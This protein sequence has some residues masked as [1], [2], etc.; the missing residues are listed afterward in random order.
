MSLTWVLLG[1]AM[2]SALPC[3]F[4]GSHGM[5][6]FIYWLSFGLPKGLQ[7]WGGGL[8][9]IPKGCGWRWISLRSARHVGGE[10]QFPQGM[11]NKL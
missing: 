6:G 3:H 1:L 10:R 9:K 8:R 2:V 5:T 7:T 4:L 11:V